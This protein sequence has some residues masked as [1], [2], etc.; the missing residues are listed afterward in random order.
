MRT[1]TQ[2]GH[3]LHG[4]ISQSWPHQC[5]ASEHFH[6]PESLSPNVAIVLS[7]MWLALQCLKFMIKRDL[8]FR[9]N[10]SIAADEMQQEDAALELDLEAGDSEGKSWDEMWIVDDDDDADDEAVLGF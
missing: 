8:Y 6:L 1:A 4:I 10:P 5:R 3:L 2:S 9:F 7:R